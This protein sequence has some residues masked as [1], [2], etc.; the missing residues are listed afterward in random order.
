MSKFSILIGEF[1]PRRSNTLF[2]FVDVLVPEMRLQIREVSIHGRSD[3]RWIGLPARPQIDPEGHVPS[4]TESARSKIRQP[5]PCPRPTCRRRPKPYRRPIGQFRSESR[6]SA[7]HRWLRLR[8]PIRSL[9]LSLTAHGHAWRSTAQLGVPPSSVLPTGCAPYSP[10]ANPLM[11]PLAR[12]G[13]SR[14]ELTS[15]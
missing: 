5:R 8:L 4:T 2:G 6:G 12:S 7:A 3:R 1:T 15:A 9:T 10:E 13:P 14:A 11:M